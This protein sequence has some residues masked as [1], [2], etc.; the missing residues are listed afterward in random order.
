MMGLEDDLYAELLE[1][2]DQIREDRTYSNGRVP[3]VCSDDALREMAQRVPTKAEDFSAIVGV[4]QRFVELYS[5][6]FLAITKKY[7]MTAAKASN[8]D[9]DLAQ[10][11]RELQKKLINISRNNRLLFQAKIYKKN[12]FDLTSVPGLD[13]MGLLFGRKTSLKLCDSTK[14]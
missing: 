13:L 12:A 7:A 2:R 3:T 11:L 9:N 8:M 14:S 6:D 1:L 10:T 5:D 4:G